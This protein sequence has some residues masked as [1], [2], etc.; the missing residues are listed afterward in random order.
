[1]RIGVL[2]T[3]MVG[4]AIAT[5]AIEVG[6]DVRMGSRTADNAEAVA[7]ARGLGPE[8]TNGTFAD[9]AADAHLVVLATAG[10]HAEA[11]LAAAGDG[12]AG[13]TV[14]DVTNALD[15]S[16]GMPPRLAVG[17]NDSIGERL[18]RAFP[19][20]RVVK[21]LN[22]MNAGVMV[23]PGAIPGE[24][25]VFLSGDDAA[26]KDAVGALLAQFGWRAAQMLDLGGI[27]TARGPEMLLPLWL[28]IAGARGGFDFNFAIVAPPG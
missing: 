18:Q 5:R 26:A 28:G 24:H 13:K 21:A 1:M 15:T 19:R 27:A 3:G 14:L 16:Q 20:A 23:R 22:T 2:G 8:A 9:A 4:K 11:A 6:H 17:P 25:V 12:V 7:W 10:L